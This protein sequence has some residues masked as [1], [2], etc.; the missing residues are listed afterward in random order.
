MKS[1]KI[2]II[3]YNV[4]KVER[5]EIAYNKQIYIRF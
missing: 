1:N 3:K 2:L 5:E 4:T